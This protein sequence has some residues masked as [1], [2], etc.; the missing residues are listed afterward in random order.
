MILLQQRTLVKERL[1]GCCLEY[2]TASKKV[3]GMSWRPSYII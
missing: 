2:M 1:F 3:A